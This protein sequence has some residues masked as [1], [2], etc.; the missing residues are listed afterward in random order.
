MDCNRG[1]VVRR[2][3]TGIGGLLAAQIGVAGGEVFGGTAGELA[4]RAVA[5]RQVESAGHLAGDIRLHL[6]DVG[7]RRIERLLP[8][9][10]RPRSTVA[11]PPRPS[12]RCSR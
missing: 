7:Q 9:R 2:R 10:L 4:P 1:G 6:E 11:M 8:F 5:Q 12:S 3:G